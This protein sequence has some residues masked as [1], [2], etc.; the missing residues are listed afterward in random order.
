VERRK[1]SEAART[2]NMYIIYIYIP[3]SVR[4]LI[5][6]SQEKSG[7]SIPLVCRVGVCVCVCVRSYIPNN[8]TGAGP[9]RILN[10]RRPPHPPRPATR[11]PPEH[12]TRAHHKQPYTILV[13]IYI[14]I[15]SIL[16]ACTSKYAIY[17]IRVYNTDILYR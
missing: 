6:Y 13:H 10:T 4:S 7:R 1:L 9:K 5:N 14:Y 11:I 15:H 12:C 16:Y 8:I 17:S 3:Y 2:R